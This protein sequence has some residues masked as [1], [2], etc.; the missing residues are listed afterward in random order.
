MEKDIVYRSHVLVPVIDSKGK[1]LKFRDMLTY[2]TI[3]S[4]L[5]TKDK[6]CYP[7][8]RAIA[9]KSK[10]SHRFVCESKN[11]LVLSGLIED[12]DKVKKSYSFTEFTEFKSIPVDILNEVELSPEEIALLIR[13]R[14]YF[15]DPSFES[16]TPC[17][18]IAENIGLTYETLKKYYDSLF[19]KG[20]IKPAIG[21]N[22]YAFTGLTDKFDWKVSDQVREYEE[23]R[24]KSKKTDVLLLK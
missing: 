3:R 10:L 15:L 16:I 1:D 5:N 7:G 9:A 4:Y 11:R 2:F 21:K 17:K 19:D 23:V 6:R 20:Y 14:Q 13:I 24:K 18:Q 22:L 8:I 12:K